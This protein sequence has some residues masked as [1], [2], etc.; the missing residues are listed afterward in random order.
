MAEQNITTFGM[1]HHW[2]K[3]NTFCLNESDGS[4]GARGSGP[5][6]GNL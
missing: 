1:K 2:V 5:N 4:P 3:G 6:R